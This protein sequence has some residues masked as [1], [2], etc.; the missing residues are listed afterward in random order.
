MQKPG[1]DRDAPRTVLV[2][3]L[4]SLLA[5][6]LREAPGVQERGE[7]FKRQLEEKLKERENTQVC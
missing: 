3:L 7:M 4:L 2:L 1:S 6:K 5:E